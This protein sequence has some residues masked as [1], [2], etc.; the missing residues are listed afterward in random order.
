MEL[1]RLSFSLS[2][3]WALRPRVSQF[4]KLLGIT[5][6]PLPKIE[7]PLQPFG[8]GNGNG[9]RGG[10]GGGR[11]GRGSPQN[12][13]DVEEI[14]ELI[15]LVSLVEL[16]D[17]ADT[18]EDAPDT[19]MTVGE[20]ELTAP[21]GCAVILSG[22]TAMSN[23][24][25]DAFM[26]ACSSEAAFM[27][28]YWAAPRAG[29]CAAPDLDACMMTGPGFGAEYHFGLRT[30]DRVF[31]AGL[32]SYI[33]GR[34]TGMLLASE[35][36]TGMLL[37]ADPSYDPERLPEVLHEAG[38]DLTSAIARCVDELHQYSALAI[39]KAGRTLL[40]R[41]SM[42][43]T[44][45]SSKLVDEFNMVRPDRMMFSTMDCGQAYVQGPPDPGMFARDPP[46]AE[47][48]EPA[49]L[50]EAHSLLK[51]TAE[52]GAAS[53]AWP[54]ADHGGDSDSPD[55][56]VTVA[57]VT[58]RFDGSDPS[59]VQPWLRDATAPLR[60]MVTAS[61]R[62]P[63]C[64]MTAEAASNTE[65][66]GEDDGDEVDDHDL[67]QLQHILCEVEAFPTVL[68]QLDKVEAPKLTPMPQVEA[69]DVIGESIGEAK[70]AS[71]GISIERSVMA[72]TAASKRALPR[73]PMMPF[74]G[75]PR[76]ETQTSGPIH[77]TPFAHVGGDEPLADLDAG[78][79]LTILPWNNDPEEGTEQPPRT[80]ITVSQSELPVKSPATGSRPGSRTA[81]MKRDSPADKTDRNREESRDGTPFR[82]RLHDA[83]DGLIS[84]VRRVLNRP[85][86]CSMGTLLLAITAAAITGV[87]TGWLVS[88]MAALTAIFW[89]AF[90]LAKAARHMLEHIGMGLY[91]LSPYALIIGIAMLAPRFLA[92]APL[93]VTG[94]NPI[95]AASFSLP[96]ISPNNA[97]PFFPVMGEIEL[98]NVEVTIGEAACSES[99]TIW[100]TGAAKN[101][102]NKIEDLEPSSIE[103]AR[104]KISGS[105]GTH[106]TSIK[107]LWR[108]SVETYGDHPEHNGYG[109]LNLPDTILNERCAFKLVAACEVKR[110]HGVSLSLPANGDAF[111]QFKN[112]A[113][114]KLLGD[115]VLLVPCANMSDIRATQ[116]LNAQATRSK[117]ITE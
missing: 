49:W 82:E 24:A 70:D 22:L 68:P 108:L 112:G 26:G 79:G 42:R 73:E 25:Q 28:A 81:D 72:N 48:A 15:E 87:V 10:R 74:Q 83:K 95:L 98:Q 21:D 56:R 9:G 88:P 47:S 39:Q 113:R 38:A 117:A 37:A 6:K 29:V 31:Q 93:G 35:H 12:A 59:T 66:D 34:V 102:T 11:G 8:R 50:T 75:T 77:A 71:F 1:W 57:A 55:D 103:K 110:T 90:Q 99:T 65:M 114:T 67:E 107:G 23:C 33:T 46:D 44:D 58:C 13:A 101:M 4:A 106:H 60:E 36:V 61:N 85:T 2:P 76:R 16:V 64:P 20:G 5:A 3:R 100:D 94:A 96:S 52:P 17:D 91:Y 54:G 115:R 105:N 45:D 19:V 14:I 104:Y 84:N 40:L 80:P 51:I 41:R 97:L 92:A 32:G 86:G 62:V 7:K 43:N 78:V 89:P 53:A 116:L 109:V 111:V 69:E 18:H 63:V 27:A 30:Y